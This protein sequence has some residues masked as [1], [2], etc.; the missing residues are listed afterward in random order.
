MEPNKLKKNPNLDAKITIWE[1]GGH[2]VKIEATSSCQGRGHD[3]MYIHIN[4]N[5][6]YYPCTLYSMSQFLN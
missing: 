5:N 3:N 1:G 2:L 6:P 4:F